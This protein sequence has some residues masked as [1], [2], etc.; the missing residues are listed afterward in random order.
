MTKVPSS[1]TVPTNHNTNHHRPLS[2]VVEAA[3]SVGLAVG[4]VLLIS[5]D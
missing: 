5:P 1:A 3:D 2:I 4:V